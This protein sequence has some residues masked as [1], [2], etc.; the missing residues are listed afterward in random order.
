M[1]Y[2]DTIPYPHTPLVIAIAGFI[3]YYKNLV[4]GKGLWEVK[5]LLPEQ[6]L[7]KCK[8]EDKKLSAEVLIPYEYIFWLYH[9]NSM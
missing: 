2:S 5:N 7:P 8:I 3:S 4:N 9:A 1:I 6:L